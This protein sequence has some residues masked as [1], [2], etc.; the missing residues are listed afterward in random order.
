LQFSRVPLTS[1][2]TSFDQARHVLEAGHLPAP[3]GVRIEDFLAAVNYGFV[4][5]T[6][7]PLALHVAAGPSPFGQAELGLLQIAVQAADL[8]AVARPATHLTLLVDASAGMR[9]GDRLAMI[10]RAIG[11]IVPRLHSGD[12]VSLVIFRRDAEILAEHA[13]PDQ[14]GVVLDELAAVEARSE[15][16]F[17]AGLRAA[18]ALA[19]GGSLEDSL[20]WGQQSVAVARR[21]VLITDGGATL[22]ANTARRVDQALAAAAAE[23]VEL[24]VID[25]GGS[26]VPDTQLAGFARAAGGRLHRAAHSREVGW[27]LTEALTGQAQSVAADASLAIEFDP[28]TVAAYRLLGHEANADGWAAPASTEMRAGQTSTALYEMRLL[29]GPSDVVGVARLRWRDPATGA[30]REEHRTIRRAD[31]ADS[32][33]RAPVS[34]QTAALVAE[35]AELLRQSYFA[36]FG[37]LRDVFELARVLGPEFHQQPTIREFLSVA[38]LALRASSPPPN[39]RPRTNRP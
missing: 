12:R 21:V 18:Y 22:E 7:Q 27:A 23:G 6:R 32:I 30:L 28:R 38:E 5:P 8:P 11:E 14:L 24:T 2:T 17:V 9:Q 39:G 35:T 34:L 1:D 20:D 4:P 19:E 16:D 15:T 36:Q 10:G 33:A 13:R 31:F 37:S 29:P 26:E 3:A 25:L